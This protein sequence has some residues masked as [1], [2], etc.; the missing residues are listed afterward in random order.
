MR[1]Q[2][3]SHERQWRPRLCPA[4]LIISN[5]SSPRLRH[6]TIG[7]PVPISMSVNGAPVVPACAGTTIDLSPAATGA[8]GPVVSI[9]GEPT[10][11][12]VAPGQCTYVYSSYM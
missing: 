7:T 12:N 11:A 6:C 1:Y 9:Q 10:S 8:I 5:H 4:F 2:A 3:M